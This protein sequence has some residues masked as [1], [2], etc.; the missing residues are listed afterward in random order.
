MAARHHGEGN[1][2]VNQFWWVV[3]HGI[4]ASTSKESCCHAGEFM[5]MLQDLNRWYLG[6][7]MTV[8]TEG[9][10]VDIIACPWMLYQ[11]AIEGFPV[12][13]FSMDVPLWSA[14]VLLLVNICWGWHWR[15]KLCEVFAA[16]SPKHFWTHCPD[17]KQRLMQHGVH[18]LPAPRDTNH[19]AFSLPLRDLRNQRFGGT[20][21]TLGNNDI[22]KGSDQMSLMKL[23][24]KK[25]LLHDWPVQQCFL[26][27]RL[28]QN[29]WAWRGIVKK[30]SGVPHVFSRH[31]RK[32]CFNQPTNH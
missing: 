29:G 17:Q 1:R 31:I 20:R 7:V 13:M 5:F 32:T 21:H 2:C 26:T 9:A 23:P 11:E 22:A 18:G 27:M 10:N 4:E 14:W 30:D 25:V 12:N 8:P 28:L 3:L 19:G 24:T 6:V 15:H 16:Y